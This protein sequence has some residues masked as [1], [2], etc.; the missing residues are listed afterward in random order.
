M[1][2]PDFQ[3]IMLPFLLELSDNRDT[4]V[5]ELT[6]SL[7]DKL[8]VTSDEREQLLPSGQQAV[9]HNRVAW[10]K[11]YLK[12]AGLVENPVRGRVRITSAG[13][14]LLK[15]NPSRIDMKLLERF[16][17]YCEFR[18]RSEPKTSDTTPTLPV[19]A[20]TKTPL[21][22]LTEA[23]QTIQEA[24]RQELLSRIRTCSPRFFEQAVVKLLLAM[25]YGGVTGDGQVTGQSGDAGID[26]VIRE[27]KLGLDVVCI[28]AKRWQNPVGRDVVQQ[29]VGSMDFIRARKGV[30][31]ST[32]TFTRDA[33]TFV[34]RIEGKKVV[35]IDGNRLAELMLSHNVGVTTTEVYN[36]KEVSN[37][38]FDE[39]DG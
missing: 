13:Q 32:S 15:E 34:D 14:A 4:S 5:R 35:L 30:I 10:A 2:I 3:S 9:F 20:P 12:A 26:G 36:L 19:V 27:D 1:A 6:D 39:D 28:Q 25:G 38:F 24:V 8:N 22:Q 23:Y 11:T 29:F 21:E 16:P 17:S 37:D 7:A 31:L 33:T 18:D